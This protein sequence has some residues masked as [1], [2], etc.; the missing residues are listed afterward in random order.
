MR[1]LHQRGAKES[2]RL[3]IYFKRRRKRKFEKEKDAP[4]YKRQ[5]IEKMDKIQATSDDKDGKFIKDKNQKE[6]KQDENR[7]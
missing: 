4:R 1:L 5:Q 2:L 3:K 6:L 7:N